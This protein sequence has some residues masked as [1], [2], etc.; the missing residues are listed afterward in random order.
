M[1][2]TLTTQDGTF[3]LLSD[4]AVFA[5]GGAH[6]LN[7]IFDGD[8]QSLSLVVDGQIDATVAA[9]GTTAPPSFW[10]LTI[11]STWND[12]V[13]ARIQDIYVL[14]EN[15]P[16]Y[17]VLYSS[18][19]DDTDAPE[20]EI[21]TLISLDFEDGEIIDTSDHGAAITQIGTGT[22]L[23]NDTAQNGQVAVISDESAISVSRNYEEIFELDSF[24]FD[25]DMRNDAE[26][27]RA[28]FR[29]HQS[30]RLD[31]VDNDLRFMLTTTEGDFMIETS[32][33]LLEDRDWHNVQ[34]SYSNDLDQLQMFID[35]INVASTTASGTTLE[36]AY[37]GLDIGNRW[38]NG[39]NG[40]I[41]DFTMLTNIDQQ[42]FDPV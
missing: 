38:G 22:S 35:G 15:I 6:E 28:V 3:E 40:E 13:D 17:D 10:G 18:G 37:W 11:G 23:A 41:D 4:T 30:F 5:D 27:G 9:S 34:I 26:N 12:A 36:R 31:V 42:Y 2:I 39:F 19:E 33:D 24:A 32:G 21:D 8:T 1:H 20:D 29:I 25:F 16:L 7:F 14:N